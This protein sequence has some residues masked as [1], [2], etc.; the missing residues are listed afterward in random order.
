[1]QLG[2][3]RACL[4]APSVMTKDRIPPSCPPGGNW[5]CRPW[6]IGTEEYYAAF[7]KNGAGLCG[8]IR[9]D[10][11]NILLCK[12]AKHLR[13]SVFF[14]KGDDGIH[15]H[16]CAVSLGRGGW[17]AAAVVGGACRTRWAGGS[18]SLHIPLLHLEGFPTC[19]VT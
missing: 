8:P 15:Q 10:T 17:P 13:A 19:M 4:L 9:C 11:Q 7:E 18:F 12:T 1:M 2:G 14:F 16:A 3:H 5:L 6:C